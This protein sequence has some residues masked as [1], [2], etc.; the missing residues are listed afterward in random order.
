MARSRV[1]ITPKC[2]CI[3]Y[4]LVTELITSTKKVLIVPTMQ[5]VDGKALPDTN[6]PK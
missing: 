4:S 6:E 1:S 3:H 2:N 5:M